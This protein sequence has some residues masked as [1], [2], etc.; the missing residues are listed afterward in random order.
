MEQIIV[1]MLKMKYVFIL[2]FLMLVE[3][4]RAINF[5]SEPLLK[6]DSIPKLN[7]YSLVIPVSFIGYGMWSL[8]DEELKEFNNEARDNLRHVDKGITIDNITMYVPALGVYA[9]NLI[10]IEGKHDFTDRT[11]VLATSHFITVHSVLKL[12]SITKINRPDGTGRSSFPSGH[13]AVAFLVAEFLN[14][15]FKHRSVWYGVAGYV[16]ATGIGYHRIYNNRHWFSDVVAGAG[17]GILGTKI[18]YWLLPTIQKIIH[19]MKKR[20]GISQVTPYYQSGKMGI[21]LSIG[22]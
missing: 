10:G 15:E 16:I 5:P 18:A 21:G 12:K 8:N 3:Y 11:I 7:I 4:G 13:T 19:P 6:L 2:L 22:F 17:F 1:V 20:L 14:Q 9:L